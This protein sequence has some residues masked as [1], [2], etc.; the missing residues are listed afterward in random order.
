[1]ESVDL[2]MVDQGN[3]STMGHRRI[4]LSNW[5][6]P[7]GLGSTGPGGKSCM[8]NMSGTGDA[9]RAW[10][11]W[12]PAGIVPVQTF[13]PNQWSSLDETGW[14]VQSEE[15]DLSGATV[16]VTSDGSSMPVQV[17]T[18]TGN[19]GAR[20]GLRIVPDGWT[21]QAGSTYDVSISGISTPISYGIQV[22]DCS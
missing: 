15:I 9:G 7:I 21:T 19:Y 3:E 12:P 14:S 16:T 8:Q 22:V 18:L 4:I 13:A 6:G 10:T 2:Y 1:V 11:P 20:Y 5:L 17:S